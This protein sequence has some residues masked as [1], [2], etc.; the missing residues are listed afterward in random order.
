V[1]LLTLVICICWLGSYMTTFID[2]LF[3]SEWSSNFVT[4]SLSYNF[5]VHLY[6][7]FKSFIKSQFGISQRFYAF[8]Y[9]T[10]R[11]IKLLY[12]Y[13]WRQGRKEC[14]TVDISMIERIKNFCMDRF[15]VSNPWRFINHTL[16]TFLSHLDWDISQ[17]ACFRDLIHRSRCM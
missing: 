15:P 4:S 9:I 17:V 16:F 8:Y 2:L 10:L 6:T 13:H 3:F 7:V 11:C 14:N 5:I 12:Y 1:K